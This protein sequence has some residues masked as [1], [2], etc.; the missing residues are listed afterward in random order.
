MGKDKDAVRSCR[1]LYAAEALSLDSPVTPKNAQDLGSEAFPAIYLLFLWYTIY[2]VISE[3]QGRV[4]RET[5][6]WRTSTARLSRR[7]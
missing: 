6:A 7:R 1:R 3:C 4:K 5:V 2:V